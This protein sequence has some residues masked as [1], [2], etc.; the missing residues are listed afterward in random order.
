M[1]SCCIKWPFVCLV[2][3]LPYIWTIVL[4]IYSQVVQHLFLSRLACCILNLANKHGI[5]LI[6]AYIHTHLNVEVISHGQDWF[7]SGTC[8]LA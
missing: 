6:P 4:L 7:R 2:R 5:T 3:W 8:F 1:P